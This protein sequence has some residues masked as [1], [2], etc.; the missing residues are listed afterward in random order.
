VIVAIDRVA[1]LNRA[2][3]NYHRIWLMVTEHMA[4]RRQD[5]VDAIV[6]AAANAGIVG[7]NITHSV[8]GESYDWT[9]YQQ[10]LGEIMNS[11]RT[12][13]IKSSGPFEVRSRGI[14]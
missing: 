12:Q 10:A 2:L 14:V 3:D 5:G 8:D 4:T 11:L 9:G 7:P 13:I 6:S 1:T